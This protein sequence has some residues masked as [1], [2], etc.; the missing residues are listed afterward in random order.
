MPERCEE[1]DRLWGDHKQAVQK[2]SRLQERLRRAE[3]R[4]DHELVEVL[5]AQL[6]ILMSEQNR[7]SETFV[8]HQARAHSHKREPQTGD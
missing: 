6:T 2:S 7:T 3:I 1:C 8:Q 4:Q 5:A